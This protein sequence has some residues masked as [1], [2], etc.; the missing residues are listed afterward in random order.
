MT[1]HMSASWRKLVGMALLWV[2]L[3]SLFRLS[4][5]GTEL[6][7]SIPL[8]GFACFVAGLSLFADGFKRSVVADLQGTP[9]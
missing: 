7:L 5:D 8:L 9:R 6:G 1:P 2:A 4:R 3:A